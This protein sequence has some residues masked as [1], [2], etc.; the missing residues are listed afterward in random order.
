VTNGDQWER[1]AN[2]FRQLGIDPTV[3]GFCDSPAFMAAERQYEGLA[4]KYARFVR[5]RRIDDDYRNRV[6]AR[7]PEVI[8]F[9]AEELARDGRL[10][11]C[12]DASSVALRI[13]ELEEI[14][15]YV[16]VGSVVA[17]FGR[18]GQRYLQHFRH[19]NNPARAGHAWLFVPPFDVV[20][21][22]IQAQPGFTEEQLELLAP[23]IAEQLPTDPGIDVQEVAESEL[24]QLFRERVGRDAR[25]EDFARP[26]MRAHWVEFP[27]KIVQQG[28]LRVKYI[29]SGIMPGDGTPFEQWSNLVLSGQTPA[30]LRGAFLRRFPQR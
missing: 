20:D 11:A 7:V 19:P 8:G 26:S 21:V 17:D 9:I 13:L 15:G 27:P 25:I 14:W 28:A 10:G 24:R 1:L 22:S 18:L 5:G 30:E 3:P 2:E 12:I 4:A 6:R 29:D 16:V 23:I